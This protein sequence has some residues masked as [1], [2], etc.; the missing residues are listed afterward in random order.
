MQLRRFEI[1]HWGMAVVLDSITEGQ[2]RTSSMQ[3]LGMI[4]EFRHY[5]LEDEDCLP[6]EHF[7]TPA[8]LRVAWGNDLSPEAFFKSLVSPMQSPRSLISPAFPIW[9][10]AGSQV[11]AQ[12]IGSEEYSELS[13]AQFVAAEQRLPVISYRTGKPM[14]DLTL[15]SS[16]RAHA[17]Q[18]RR[19]FQPSGRDITNTYNQADSTAPAS[20]SWGSSERSPVAFSDALS[21][22]AVSSSF[23]EDDEASAE[24]VF[25]Q[26]VLEENPWFESLQSPYDPKY[27][28]SHSPTFP[29]EELVETTEGIGIIPEVAETTPTDQESEEAAAASQAETSQTTTAQVIRPAQKLHRSL[30]YRGVRRRPWGKFAAEIRDSAQNGA[31]IWLGT[32]DTAEDAAVAYDQAAFEM[33]GCRAL[34]NFPLKANIYSANL[35]AKAHL[36]PSS[37][38]SPD[39]SSDATA[40]SVQKLQRKHQGQ[41]HK[42]NIPPIDF[43][44]INH[45]GMANL[46]TPPAGMATSVGSSQFTANPILPQCQVPPLIDERLMQGLT[47]EMQYRVALWQRAAASMSEATTPASALS[48]YMQLFLSKQRRAYEE[49]LQFPDRGFHFPHQASNPLGFEAA[50]QAHHQNAVPTFIDSHIGAGLKRERSREYWEEPRLWPPPV[51]RTC[52]GD[53]WQHQVQVGFY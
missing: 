34:L 19:A 5:L 11:T 33:R 53:Q 43:S 39:H 46:Q 24:D 51:K 13:D 36:D 12:S 14:A 30:N 2:P 41:Q 3:S 37:A 8:H 26:N 49:F 18:A 15:P 35:A 7:L 20:S 17:A 25:L 21:S 6:E 45:A 42:H 31:R 27:G 28:F 38:N 9:S 32:Y 40:S 22:A 50:S 47:P 1:W 44:N 52:R 29:S 23:R 10:S 48:A 16:Y 4:E